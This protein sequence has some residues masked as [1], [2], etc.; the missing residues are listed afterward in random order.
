MQELKIYQK[1]YDMVLFSYPALKNFPKAER[2]T[3]V[4]SIKESMYTVL[5]LIIKAQKA[6][7]KTRYLYRLDT[8][9]EVLST[10]VRLGAELQFLSIKKY[11]IWSERLTEIGKMLGGWIKRSS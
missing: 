3:L 6:K 2:H 11:K 1:A 10:K 4:A 7:K 5:E 8:E 9:M